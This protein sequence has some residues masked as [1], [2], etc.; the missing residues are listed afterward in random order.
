MS[1]SEPKRGFWAPTD[2]AGGSPQNG[3]PRH[4][5]RDVPKYRTPIG[6]VG[7]LAVSLGVGLAVANSAGLARADIDPDSSVSST[8]PES[9]DTSAESRADA[10]Q[11]SNENDEE[12]DEEESDDED[13]V[14]ELDAGELGVEELSGDNGT[15]VEAD[16]NT[17]EPAEEL[18]QQNPEVPE[19]EPMEETQPPSAEEQTAD[20]IP[21]EPIAEPST[22]DNHPG[23]SGEVPDASAVTRS[24]DEVA[25]EPVG[26]AAVELEPAADP[27][28]LISARTTTMSTDLAPDPT[29]PV[30][31]TVA[32]AE[33]SVETVNLVSA[34]VSTVVSPFADPNAPAPT[35]W[36][37]ALLAWVRRQIVHTFFNESPVWGPIEST[38]IVTGQVLI[39][40]HDYD[41]NGDPLSYTIIQPTN[42]IVI[43][44]PLTGDF[45]YTPKIPVTGAPLVDSFQVVISDSGEHLKGLIGLIQGVFH[46]LSRWIGLAESDDVTVTIPVIATPIVELPPVV[47]TVPAALG[48]T[49][50]PVTVSPIV[51]IT[52]LDSTELTS[53]TVT[54]TDATA[55]QVLGYGTL[56]TG[57]ST[58]G[59]DAETASV[60]FTGT[61]SLAAYRQLLSSVTFISPDIALTSI[62]FTVT[63]SQDNSSVPVATIITVLGLPVAVA[64]LVVTAPVAAGTTGAQLTVS[65]VVLITDLD[66][67]QLSSATVT[68][69]DPA[70]GQVLGY[71]TLPAGI[72]AVAGAGSV[73]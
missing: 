50:S 17:D 72:T 20:G 15:L 59:F 33:D 70:A 24:D 35:P 54:I 30:M 52:D 8:G 65:P 53:A 42:G 16:A 7:A 38:Q 67:T 6:R 19:A 22:P 58:A 49:G 3:T 68:I 13:K 57:I 34:L 21:A 18:G 39:D 41:P 69:N 60:T 64:P 44:D 27:S 66:S 62:V 45:I 40:L 26:D 46:S 9:D 31:A 1:A 71:G 25:P 55:G 12:E 4:Q 36:F 29:V 51:V 63:D 23:A 5:R 56:P 48:T 47:V 10:Q 28:L 37:D 14:E 61:A 11:S 32:P 43:R 2:S 73:T